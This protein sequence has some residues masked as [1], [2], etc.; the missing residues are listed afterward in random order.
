MVDLFFIAIAEAKNKSGS[1]VFF[2]P[3][4]SKEYD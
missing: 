3:A 1:T 4:I 2:A